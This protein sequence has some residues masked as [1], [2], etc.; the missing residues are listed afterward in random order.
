MALDYEALGLRAVE[1]S[2]ALSPGSCGKAKTWV[3][4]RANAG[5]VIGGGIDSAGLPVTVPIPRPS[6]V[7]D[8]RSSAA[9]TQGTEVI[10]WLLY[11]SPA[12]GFCPS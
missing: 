1:A 3:V 11:L 12:S 4:N 2:F 5:R 8:G 9:V 6:G 10:F 7:W